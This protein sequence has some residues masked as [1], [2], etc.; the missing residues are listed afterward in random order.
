MRSYIGAGKNLSTKTKKGK[1]LKEMS[2]AKTPVVGMIETG[3]RVVTQVMPWV[4][5]KEVFRNSF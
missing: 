5:K 3:G 2:A 1:N 4:T